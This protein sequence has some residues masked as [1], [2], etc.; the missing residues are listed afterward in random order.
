MGLQAGGRRVAGW[1]TSGC[2]LGDVG[3][4][5]GAQDCRPRACGLCTQERV[6]AEEH[7]E[8]DQPDAPHI[9]RPVVGGDLAAITAHELGRQIVVRAADRLHLLALAL[10]EATQPEV[11]DEDVRVHGLVGEQYVLGLEVAVHHAW[12]SH[13]RRA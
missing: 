1:G 6:E 5:A 10:Q 7:D 4:Q 8:G 3:L 13:V 11:G 9:D 12:V 2:R